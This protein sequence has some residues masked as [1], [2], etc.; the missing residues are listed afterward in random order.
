MQL[1]AFF[2]AWLVCRRGIEASRCSIGVS[3]F[4]VNLDNV[5]FRITEENCAMTPVWQVCWCS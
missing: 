4:R 2:M 3:V 5:V 1:L